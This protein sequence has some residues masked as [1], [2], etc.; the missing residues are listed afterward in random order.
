MAKYKSKVVTVTPS[1]T[2]EQ[3][4]TAL[5]TQLNQGWELK[6]VVTIT[7]TNVK[8]VFIKQVTA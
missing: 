6:Q 2:N 4:T 3:F 8:A 7:S 1:W 5:D